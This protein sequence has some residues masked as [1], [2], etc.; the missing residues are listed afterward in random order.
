MR[1]CNV[2]G[3]YFTGEASMDPDSPDIFPSLLDYSE[4]DQYIE[5]PDIMDR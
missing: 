5:A 2:N 4:Q 1:P 3:C